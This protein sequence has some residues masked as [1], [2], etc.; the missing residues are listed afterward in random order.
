MGGGGMERAGIRGALAYQGRAC[1]AID[2]DDFG[3][4]RSKIRNVIDSKRHSGTSA[5]RTRNPTSSAE[6]VAGF[7]VRDFV[8]SRNDGL[9]IDSRK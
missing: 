6:A 7:R 9:M 8:A 4:N 1:R 5:G 3:S 2:H